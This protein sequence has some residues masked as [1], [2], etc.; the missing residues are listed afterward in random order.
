M[1]N[2][3]KEMRIIPELAA[4]VLSTVNYESEARAFEFIYDKD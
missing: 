3:L 2:G 1:L 4:Y